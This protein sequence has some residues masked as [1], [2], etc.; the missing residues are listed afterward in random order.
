MVADYARVHT[1]PRALYAAT[2]GNMAMAGLASSAA[3]V[4]ATP[5]SNGSAAAAAANFQNSLA[6]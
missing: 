2:G 5:Y 3:A 1:S 6:G 4:Y